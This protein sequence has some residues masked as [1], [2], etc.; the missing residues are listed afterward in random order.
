MTYSE[1]CFEAK[2]SEA[3]VEKFEKISKKSLTSAAKSAK[4]N[5]LSAGGLTDRTLKIEQY[6]KL[7]RNLILTC[8]DTRK[9]IPNKVIQART[10]RCGL[11]EKYSDLST[12]EVIKY[13]L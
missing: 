8:R 4:L 9:T 13:H 6:R 5:K 12:L 10:Q 7:V 11:S 1:P 2:H 3:A